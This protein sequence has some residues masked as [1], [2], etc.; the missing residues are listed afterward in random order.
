MARIKVGTRTVQT[1]RARGLD[2]DDFVVAGQP[3][4]DDRRGEQQGNRNGVRE[5]CWESRTGQGA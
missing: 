4:V 1:L 5:A 2:G 3:A